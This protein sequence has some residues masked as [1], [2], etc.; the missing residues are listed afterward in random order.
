[1]SLTKNARG[2]VDYSTFPVA[3]GQQKNNRHLPFVLVFDLGVVDD[4]PHEVGE[5]Q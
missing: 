2:L 3:Q 5:Y 4:Y 1:M